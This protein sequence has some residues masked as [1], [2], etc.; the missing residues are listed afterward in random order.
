MSW[1][2]EIYLKCGMIKMLGKSATSGSV[3]G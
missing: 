2:S 1:G 3:M